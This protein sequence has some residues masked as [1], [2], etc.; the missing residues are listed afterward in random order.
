MYTVHLYFIVPLTFL[1]AVLFNKTGRVCAELAP[2]LGWLPSRQNASLSQILH[3]QSGEFVVYRAV[4]VSILNRHHVLRKRVVHNTP[5]FCK[6]LQHSCADGFLAS[7]LSRA[8]LH[9]SEEGE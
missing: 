6:Y 2:A 3:A 1:L 5:S 8:L 4:Y 9:E 7:L